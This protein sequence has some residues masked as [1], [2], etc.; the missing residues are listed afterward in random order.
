VTAVYAVK[1]LGVTPFDVA[2]ANAMLDQDGWKRGSD[3]TR[4]K[5]GAKLA[6]DFATSAGTPDA[7]NQIELIRSTWS[8]IGVQIA[9][10]RYPPNLMF[11]PI[12]NGGIVYSNKYDMILFA[13]SNDAIG[14][15]S[16]IYS[17]KSFPPNGQNNMRWC[18]PQAQAA[19]DA[20][21]THFDQQQ[22]NADVHSFEAAYVKDVPS[23]VISLHEDLYAYNS[24]LK[25]YHPNNISPF[26]NMMDVDI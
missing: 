25:N 23:I 15:Y 6:F 17:C 7:D 20:L 18:N 4:E 24:D 8:Q 14:D 1:D 19:M 16:S 10:K 2:K 9:V 26:D 3:G 22:R 12:E 5:N 13:W 11:A 21:F